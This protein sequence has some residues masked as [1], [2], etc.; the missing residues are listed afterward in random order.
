VIVS[1]R[2]HS[3]TFAGRS[4]RAGFVHCFAIWFALLAQDA[5]CTDDSAPDFAKLAP[6]PAGQDV[7]GTA[8][9]HRIPLS[10]SDSAGEPGVLNPGD[11]F[12]A[13][14]TLCERGGKRT[15]WLLY[16]EALAAS[17]RELRD[18]SSEPLVLYSGRSNRFEFA[19]SPALVRLQTI[20]PFTGAAART[21]PREDSATFSLD[22]GLLS[23]GLDRAAAITWRAVQMHESGAFYFGSSPP[24][25]G[26]LSEAR[27]VAER[28]HL[29]LEDE[30]E[31]AGGIPALFS[32]FD[33]VQHTEGL[34]DI[35]FKVVRKPSL[36][37]VIRHVG[38]KVNLRFD[39]KHV[40]PAKPE[41]WGLPT[42]SAIYYFPLG[43]DLNGQPALKVTFA[44]T[45]AR[46]PLL[47]CGGIIGML[48]E[49]PGD[50]ETY[51]TLRIVSARLASGAAL[52]LPEAEIKA[53]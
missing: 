9:S 45:S 38:V 33:V 44:V 46:P 32:Y 21:K 26:Q 10:G 29:T 41:E 36:W 53:R 22:K 15:Q 2:T 37:S 34:E 3:A 50:K 4:L 11:S 17:P 18:Q 16:L 6:I 25:A 8:Q 24:N 51:L 28:L 43:I 52:A 5:F 12:T 31:L 7:V 40:T 49:R 13:L 42:G 47:A 20:G 14:A 30:R 39:V 1:F 23:M 27:R 35:L 19:S 48:A